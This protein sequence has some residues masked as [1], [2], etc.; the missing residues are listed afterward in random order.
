IA[1][2]VVSAAFT[3]GEDLL[4]HHRQRRDS[5]WVAC[6]AIAAVANFLWVWLALLS[7]YVGPLPTLLASR[8]A[9]PWQV[10]AVTVGAVLLTLVPQN[11]WMPAASIMLSQ[12]D[13]PRPRRSWLVAA[14]MLILA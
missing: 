3:V 4:I 9:N 8:A 11:I 12:F 14:A 7:A 6:M 5:W 13:K 10:G 2:V 1:S